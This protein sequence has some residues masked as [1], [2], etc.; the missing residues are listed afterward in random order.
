[1]SD[2]ESTALELILREETNNAE[3]TVFVDTEQDTA[4]IPSNVGG[5]LKGISEQVD[6]GPGDSSDKIRPTDKE[7]NREE[8]VFSQDTERIESRSFRPHDDLP[9]RASG[10]I[11]N[12]LMKS[13]SKDFRIYVEVDDAKVVDSASYTE[14]ETVSN[15]LSN[16][17]AYQRSDGSYV[18]NISDYPF[19]NDIDVSIAPQSQMTFDLVRTEIKVDNFTTNVLQ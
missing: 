8:L 19:S 9:L 12:I 1:L 18:V 11:D 2:F 15:E 14:L 10:E 7:V 6:F 5:E 16:I 13:Q 4:D 17:S 3:D